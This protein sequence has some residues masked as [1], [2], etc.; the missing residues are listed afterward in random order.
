MTDALR[1]APHMLVSLVCEDEKTAA[2]R[3]SEKLDVVCS[4]FADGVQ[5]ETEDWQE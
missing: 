3:T 1:L 5:K 2:G 4:R